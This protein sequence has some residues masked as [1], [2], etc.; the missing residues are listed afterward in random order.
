M[1]LAAFLGSAQT[2]PLFGFCQGLDDKIALAGAT[3]LFVDSKLLFR[4]SVGGVTERSLYL[5]IE[6]LTQ[7]QTGKTC[8]I[9]NTTV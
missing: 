1:L 5:H 7:L 6:T 8:H 3:T 2:P 4:N 9:K